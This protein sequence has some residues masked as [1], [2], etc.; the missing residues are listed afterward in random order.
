MNNLSV[1]VDTGMFKALVD[2]KD[3]FHN[4]AKLIWAKLARENTLLVTSNYILDE[5]FTLIRSRCG[6]KTVEKFRESLL[7]STL[8]LT[9]VRV[10]VEDENSA[11]KWFLYD[12]EKL[13]FTDCVSFAIMKRLR[14]TR[15]AT[16]DKDFEKPEFIIERS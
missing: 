9:I 13:S 2:A 10:T 4:Q 12:W 16:F 8:A 3:E 14:I 7:E 1:F 11:W 6:I 15:A 5:S